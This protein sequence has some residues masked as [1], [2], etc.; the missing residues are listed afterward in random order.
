MPEYT[1]HVQV[2][3]RQGPSAERS[4]YKPSALSKGPSP[5]DNCLQRKN[6]YSPEESH[7]VYDMNHI[8]GGPMPSSRRPTENEHSEI[9]IY[10]DFLFH[11]NCFVYTFLKILL[12]FYLYIVV[13]DFCGFCV[14]IA[15]FCV[16][17]YL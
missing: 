10:E 2:Q 14:F 1:E 13:S 5:T 15:L 3:A 16:S 4:R 9:S 7:W 17:L 12:V 11:I 6:S 8:K